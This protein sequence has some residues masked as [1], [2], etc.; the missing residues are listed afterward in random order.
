[1]KKTGFTLIELMIVVA[2]I[3]IIAAIAIPNL[4]RSQMSANEASAI[5][6]LRTIVTAQSQFISS[7][8]DLGGTSGF[9]P[10]YGDMVMLKD[11]VPPFIDAVL[12]DSNNPAKSGYI[13]SFVLT[14]GDAPGFTCRANAASNRSGSRNFFI[15][16]SGVLTW[17]PYDSGAAD[18]VSPVLQ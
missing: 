7:G 8:T 17:M 10:Q 6:S 5:G 1:M 13:F 16:N 12:G 2:I 9:V 11:A 4:L 15:D 3:A 18:S 14:P